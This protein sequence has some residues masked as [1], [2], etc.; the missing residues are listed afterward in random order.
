[1]ADGNPS[2][3]DRGQ[4]VLGETAKGIV[5]GARGALFNATIL[6]G[7]GL[8]FAMCFNP[9]TLIPGAALLVGSAIAGVATG[10]VQ[11]VLETVKDTFTL[12][13]SGRPEK[14]IGSF[15]KTAATLGAAAW[16]GVKMFG[17]V[18][19]GMSFSLL[20]PIASLAPLV[21]AILPVLAIAVGVP[22]LV[23]GAVDLIGGLFTSHQGGQAVAAG[24]ALDS[25]RKENNIVRK[26][27]CDLCIQ[28]EREGANPLHYPVV[29]PQKQL[30]DMQMGTQGMQVT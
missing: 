11:G 6:G 7:M 26:Q 29:S 21:P 25:N 18:G 12:A 20:S 23:S 30:P 28:K 19:T 9:I 3:I 2:L 15:I 1:M 24:R 27:I 22:A 4:Y 16:A 13:F 8:G 10:A 14:A 5:K 17:A